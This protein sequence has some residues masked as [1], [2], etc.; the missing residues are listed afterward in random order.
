[1]SHSCALEGAGKSAEAGAASQDWQSSG[2]CQLSPSNL[3][4]G[5]GQTCASSITVNLRCTHTIPPIALDMLR[6]TQL[7][8]ALAAQGP[9]RPE[10]VHRTTS[11]VLLPVH[12]LHFRVSQVRRV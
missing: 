3:A 12:K 5:T 6:C 9:R 1:M 7:T 10:P 11:T 2:D 4:E 8:L